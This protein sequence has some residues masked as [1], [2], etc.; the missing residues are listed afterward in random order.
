MRERIITITSHLS[1]R[2][3]VAFCALDD[4]CYHSIQYLERCE[5]GEGNQNSVSIWKYLHF[6]FYP[7]WL[8]VFVCRCAV[9]V[10]V[11]VRVCDT[12]VLCT[13]V[14]DIASLVQLY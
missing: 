10:C 1:R 11:Y 4:V 9:C 6:E 13:T 8:R 14:V 12:F 3:N 7:G 5:L 2:E